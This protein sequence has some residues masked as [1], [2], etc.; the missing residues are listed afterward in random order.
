[1]KVAIIT[2]THSGAGNDS[3]A[4]NDYFL[5]FY[6]EVF[7]P[8]L[9]E[10]N[11]KNVIHLGDTFDRRKYINFNT[12]Y[13]WQQ[14]VFEPLNVMC[15]RVDIL[16]GNHDTYY[17]N[18]NKINSVEELLKIYDKF[19][20]YPGPAE[21][22]IGKANVLYLPW[23]CEDNYDKSIRMIEQS[24]SKVCMGHL[25]LIGFEMYAGHLNV[26]KGLR[27]ELFDKFYMTLSGHF[28]QK[29]SR[30]GIHYLGA[31][32]PMMWG[33]WGS[34]K[35]FHVLDTET[36]EL[37]FVENPIQIFHK[38]YYN[39]SSESYDSLMSRDF[40]QLNGML[41]KVIVQKK[42]NPYWFDQFLENIQKNNPHDVSVVE[43]S[44]EEL[45]SDEETFDE[46]KD[47]LTI[48]KECAESLEI[49][50]HKNLLNDLLRDL[51]IEALNSNEQVQGSG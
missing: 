40:S 15:D 9:R 12:L 5:K 42:N 32:Y 11:I 43:A 45:T 31:P 34:S 4:M 26:D 20:F 25:E 44:F 38:I 17:K 48:L 8:Y 18:T 1:M 30:G 10:H 22:S 27:G 16:V 47:T 29:S 35:G 2:D 39:D 36:L 41:V 7:F 51:Y 21:V 24:S 3:Q 23:I 13:S 46:T 6:E 37:Q 19:N 50:A 49:G 33:D 28:H 14:R